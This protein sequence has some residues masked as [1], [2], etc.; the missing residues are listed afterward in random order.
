M[1]SQE[2]DVDC[3]DL[4]KGQQKQGYTQR[5]TNR[6]DDILIPSAQKI[7]H[8]NQHENVHVDS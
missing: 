8:R 5:Q 1:A 2:K 7:A 3:G 4:G 6:E